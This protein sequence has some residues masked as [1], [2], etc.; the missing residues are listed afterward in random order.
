MERYDI[1][2]D[3]ARVLEERARQ[4]EQMIRVKKDMGGESEINEMLVESIKAKLSILDNL[5]E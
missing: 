3:K 5:D 1:L 2:R 4:K